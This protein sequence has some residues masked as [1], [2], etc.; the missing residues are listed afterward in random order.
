MA[1]ASRTRPG[2]PYPLGATWDGGGVN[3]ALF[4]EHAT[5]VALCLFDERDPG[6][7][8]RQIRVEQRT[9]Q[10]WHVYVPGIRPGARY[11]YRVNGPYEPAQG[12]RFNPAKALLDPYAK[13]IAGT[14]E[15]HDALFGYRIGDP[16]EDGNPD[17]RDSGPYLPKSVVVDP[18]FDWENDRPPLTRWSRTVIYEVHVKGF[19]RLHPDV[20]PELRG[21][22]AGL[23]SDAALRHLTE[24]GVTAVELLPVHHSVTE[25][26]QADR[27]LANYWGYN[28]IGFFCPDSRFSSSGHL[29]QQVSE[30]KAMV[31][32]LHAAGIEVI[33]DVVYNHT[34]EGN[35]LGPTLCFRGIDN[36]AYYRLSPED[37]RTYVDYT[38]TGN[39]LNMRHPRT[40]QLMMDSLRYWV[41]D[42][43]VDGFRFDLASALARELHDV[44]RLSAFF[45]VIHQDP[46]ISQVKLIAEPWD[47]GQGG[48]Q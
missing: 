7:E 4:S 44:D 35:H 16:A 9:D 20:P 36:D 32:N 27:G 41:L 23:A 28:S 11:A 5:A 21:T 18:T 13:A 24:L 8:L 40:I 26:Y 12:H 48:Y 42:M 14:F 10:V 22:Y 31:R 45:D 46:V 1:E 25:K 43:H 19:T 30:F 34:A 47:L 17:D 6:K 15:W 39:T 29:G 33:L 37:P 38:G 2:R 3:F